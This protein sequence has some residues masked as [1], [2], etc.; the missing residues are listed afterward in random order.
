MLQQAIKEKQF[1]IKQVG[2]KNKRKLHSAAR[3]PNKTVTSSGLTKKTA[4]KEER[5]SE[6]PFMNYLESFI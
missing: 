4:E 2:A 6:T 1:K 5:A 3:P